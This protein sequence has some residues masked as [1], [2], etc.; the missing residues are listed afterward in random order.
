MI[1]ID[2]RTVILLAGVMSSFMALILFSLKRSYPPAIKGLGEWATA[3][4]LVAVGCGL[5][6]GLGL[7]PT[8][9]SI[10]IPR[11][12]FPTG[13][14]LAYVGTQR[15]FGV[16][17]QFGPWVLLISIGVLAQAWFTFVSPSYPVRL[18]I[19]N[20][21]GACL[22][23]AFA[24]LVR[25]QGAKSL[26]QALTLG[27]LVTMLVI[28][29][30]RLLTLL[31][32]PVG[33]NMFDTSPQHLVYVTGFSFFVVLLSVSMVLLAAER[34][35][36][37]V[38]YLASH[39]SLTNAL[40]RRHLNAVCAIEL[41]RSDRSGRTMALLVMDLDHF[42]VINDT[43][44][45]QRGDQVLVQF[46]TKVNALLRRP[47]Q[48]GRFGGEE[49]VAVLPETSLD[50]AQRVAERIRQACAAPSSEPSCSVSIGV[51]TNQS[52]GDTVD[53]LIAR[54]DA[55]MYQAKARGRNRV[56]TA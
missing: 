31:I 5:A 33:E 52:R 8:L 53:S 15:F 16:T 12:L 35:H 50:E 18:A 13:L 25:K 11:I 37:E 29:V 42:K 21:M 40:T 20:V 27:V 49:F 2:P 30:M 6:A 4:V 46:V 51:T 54:A 26:A 23:F 10:T 9:V 19:S 48:L 44:G 17:P 3:L 47:D 45:H 39:D 14:F 32:W 34:L 36:T 56:E 55:A 41:V 22:F 28:V 38:A 7:F 24:N 1:P 43:H